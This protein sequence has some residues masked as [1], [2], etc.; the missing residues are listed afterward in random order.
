MTLSTMQKICE[1]LEI[2]PAEIFQFISIKTKEEM[3][4]FISKKLE[5]IKEKPQTT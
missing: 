2:E 5:N 3:Y 1:V 4:D